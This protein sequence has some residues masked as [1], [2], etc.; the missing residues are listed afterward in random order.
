MFG[1][2]T[3]RRVDWEEWRERFRNLPGGV[4]GV[5]LSERLW[6]CGMMLA[7]AWVEIASGRGERSRS[8]SNDDDMRLISH[9]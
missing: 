6:K 3:L 9:D 4:D 2:S 5:L 8:S 7:D 1:S